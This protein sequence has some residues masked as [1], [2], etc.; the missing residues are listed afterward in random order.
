MSDYPNEREE[1]R[2]EA[3]RKPAKSK[4]IKLVL[5]S[6]LIEF[7]YSHLTNG[8]SKFTFINKGWVKKEDEKLFSD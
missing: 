8:L 5:T 7:G 1:A 2:Q 4:S 6:E 3:M